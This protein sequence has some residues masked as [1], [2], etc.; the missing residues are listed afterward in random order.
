MNNSLTDK[1]LID[2]FKEGTE[3]FLSH[4][5]INFVV[6]GYCHPGLQVLVHKIPGQDTWMVPGGFVKKN[7]SLEDAAYRN[8]KLSGIE[9]VFLRQIGTFGDV[10][11]NL[12]LSV[13][14]AVLTGK[15]GNIMEWIRQRFVTVVY[16]GLVNLSDITVTPGGFLK[17]FEW[18]DIN[19][20]DPMA[21]DHREIVMETRKVLAQELL[22]Y[23]VVFSLMPDVFTLN[24]LRGL[25]ESILNREIDRG[26]F[27]KKILKLGIVKKMDQRKD[28]AGRPSY[29]YRIN[30][31][32][33]QKFLSE[34]TRFGF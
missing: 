19:N 21:M 12:D 14:N 6:M 11:R 13:L 20:L 29:L 24:E 34:E 33:Y 32:T 4:V 1:I 23:P 30:L 22:S 31:H 2:Y 5:S 25:F 3:A 18:K 17:D 10:N 16:Y 26:T 9:N 15:A 7:E 27:R 8:L 28:T